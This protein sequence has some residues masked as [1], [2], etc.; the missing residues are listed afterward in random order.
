MRF[1]VFAV[2]AAVAA[3]ALAGCGEKT[4]TVRFAETEGIYVDVGNLVYQ[5]QIS[6][7]LNPA[8]REDRE[9]LVGIPPNEAQPTGDEIWFGVW[10]RVKNYSNETLQPTR[11][12][13]INDTEG[14]KYYP[15]NLP[16]SNP[17]AYNPG[18]LGAD[19]VYPLPDTAAASGPIQGSL[20]LFKLKTEST[21]NRPLVLHIQ[22]PGQDEATI[23]LDL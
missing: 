10:M 9:Y 19:Q 2:V 13:V 23:D 7:Y 12:F 3:L 18:P 11:N 6:R 22:Q 21:S 16:K 5:V 8:D 15:V 4:D 1:R 14:N 20:I 17:F